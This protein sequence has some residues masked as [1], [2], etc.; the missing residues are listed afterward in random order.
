MQKRGRRGEEEE[1]EKEEVKRNTDKMMIFCSALVMLVAR[2]Y[3]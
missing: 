3:T 2:Q 1:R